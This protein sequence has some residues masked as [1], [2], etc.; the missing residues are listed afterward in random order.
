LPERKFRQE[1]LFA[2]DVTKEEFNNLLINGW[3]RFGYYFF[4][5]SCI[6]CAECIPIR[7]RINKFSLSNSQKRVV[8][9]NEKVKLLIKKLEYSEEI[10][11]IYKEHSSDRFNQST[12][13]EDFIETFFYDSVPAFQSEYYLNDELIAFGFIDMSSEALSSVYFVFK[14]KYNFLS[15]GTFSAI[16]EMEYAR[17]LGLK[18]YYLGYYIKENHHMSY[19]NKFKPYDLFDWNEKKWKEI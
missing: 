18:Y 16:K 2:I 4:R 19:K 12:K 7:V 13:Q 17:S 8:K 9:K 10:F 3:R 14:T 5:P 11:N 1:Y 6:K 15:L